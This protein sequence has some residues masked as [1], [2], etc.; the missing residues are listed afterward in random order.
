MNTSNPY[1]PSPIIAQKIPKQKH[2]L[3]GMTI[4]WWLAGTLVVNGTILP[5]ASR[6]G[7]PSRIEIVI[8]IV[9]NGLFFCALLAFA[10]QRLLFKASDVLHEEADE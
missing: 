3:T 10:I 7:G 5:A 8:V 1:E 6:I 4:L 9:A 2:V